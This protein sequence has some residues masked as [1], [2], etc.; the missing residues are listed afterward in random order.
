MIKDIV[1]N[2]PLSPDRTQTAR[3]AVS[4]ARQ[5]QAH[6]AG[7][8][9]VYDPVLPA[10]DMGVAVPRSYVAEAQAAAQA[11]ADAA[12]ADFEERVRRDGLSAGSHKFNVAT[13]GAPT[14]FAEIAR[15]FDL[16]IVS[17]SEFNDD[18]I[19]SAIAETTLFESGGPVLVVPYIQ[20]DDLKLDRVAVCWD[21]SRPAARAIADAMP[22]IRQSKLTSL[23]VVDNDQPK[24]T[25]VPGIDI[26]RHIA[27][28]GVNVELKNL[29]MTVDVGTTILNFISDS[30]IDFLV[31]GG[32]GH[33]R[34]RQFILGGATRSIL[35]S[36]TVPTLMSH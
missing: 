32:Y 23:I 8:A 16:A 18:V 30:S 3:F 1:V 28:H 15:R 19:D 17:Q 9:F 20:K 10:V 11:K 26:A 21:G 5:F 27:R 24:S 14:Q 4:V 7:V 22:F 6:L 36:M 34:L 2:L 13:V 33:S 25:D 31:M 35:E 12:A 29:P